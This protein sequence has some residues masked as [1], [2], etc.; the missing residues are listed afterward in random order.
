MRDTV[1][2]TF[3]DH[4][5]ATF[6]Q[7]AAGQPNRVRC[8]RDRRWKYAVYLDPTGSTAAEYELYDLDTD[9][10][11][12]LNLVVTRGGRG[13]TLEARRQAAR[14]ARAAGAGV[15]RRRRHQPTAA[16]ARRRLARPAAVGWSLR[17]TE[18]S[19]RVV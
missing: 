12:A 14:H 16:R 10:D 6:M 8:V 3:D 18:A 19:Q 17:T 5:A 7:D 13:R 15:R 4:Q 9:P 11:E 1:L 2:F